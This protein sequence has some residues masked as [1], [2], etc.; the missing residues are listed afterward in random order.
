MAGPILK[1]C[2][3]VR[4]AFSFLS[5][6][7]FFRPHQIHALFQPIKH[8][9]IELSPPPLPAPSRPPVPVPSPLIQVWGGTQWSVPLTACLLYRFCIDSTRLDMRR[10]ALSLDER[11]SSRHEPCLGLLGS[12][13]VIQ[14]HSEIQSRPESLGVVSS[15]YRSTP[16]PPPTFCQCTSALAQTTR[17]HGTSPTVSRSRGPEAKQVLTDRP[18]PP[19]SADQRGCRERTPTPAPTL[20]CTNFCYLATTHWHEFSREIITARITK[21]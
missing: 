6:T 3:P 13:W 21:W 14:S 2:S 16:P 10:A 12:S 20:G 7:T 1:S 11:Y 17:M 19:G 9:D 4:M 5:V 18:P 8:P 15:Q